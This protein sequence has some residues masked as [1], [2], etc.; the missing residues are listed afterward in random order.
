MPGY[1]TLQAIVLLA[2]RTVEFIG[3]RIRIVDECVD[4]VGCGAPGDVPLLREGVLQR[5]VVELIKLLL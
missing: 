1:T 4:A 5:V 2:L 3:I